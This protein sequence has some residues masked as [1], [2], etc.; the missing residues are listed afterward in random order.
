MRARELPGAVALGLLASLLAHTAAYGGGHA[1]GGAYHTALVAGAAGGALGA[2]IAALSLAWASAGRALDGS[3][4]AARLRAGLP[5]WPL[6]TLAATAWFAFGETLEAHHDG[7]AIPLVAA[8]LVASAYV[9]LFFARMA[10]S[11]LAAIVIAIRVDAF[12]PRLS[13]WQRLT[14]LPAPVP[15]HLLRADRRYA[16]PPPSVFAGA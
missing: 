14:L 4:L 3:I 15:R 13:T 2:L 10:L 16:R 6:L 7:V 5:S 12:A 8:A 1:M 11:F 9:V